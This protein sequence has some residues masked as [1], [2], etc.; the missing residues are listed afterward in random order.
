M[1]EI[2]TD[3]LVYGGIGASIGLLATAA[4]FLKRWLEGRRPRD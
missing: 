2:A 4:L 1:R 3:L